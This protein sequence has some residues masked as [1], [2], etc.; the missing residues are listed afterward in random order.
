MGGR[1][2]HHLIH[3]G[4]GDDGGGLADLPRDQPFLDGQ[5]AVTETLRITNNGIDAGFLN[6]VQDLPA[7]FGVGRQ[8]LFDK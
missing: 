1:H 2:R 8:R 3:E 5:K 7:F 6:G 4:P